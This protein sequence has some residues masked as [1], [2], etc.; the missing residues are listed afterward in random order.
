MRSDSSRTA[1]RYLRRPVELRVMSP[2]EEKELRIS[3]TRV[4]YTAG[5]FS[6]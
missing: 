6:R 3:S 2:A 1:W 5:F 4:L